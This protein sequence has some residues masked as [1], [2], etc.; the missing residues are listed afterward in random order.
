MYLTLQAIHLT[1]HTCIL[2]AVSILEELLYDRSCACHQ[3]WNLSLRLVK[4]LACCLTRI[5][6]QLQLFLQSPNL[7]I[8][9]LFISH[10]W[11]GNSFCSVV[12]LH[13]VMGL[14]G[15]N[16]CTLFM[17]IVTIMMVRFVISKSVV[18]QLFLRF[19]VTGENSGMP[20]RWSKSLK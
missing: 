19:M 8:Y 2:Y 1:F 17:G 18:R 20:K 4:R 16:S 10:R 9:N 14:Y 5:T 13:M 11:I 12:F 7:K 15:T 3:S 6:V